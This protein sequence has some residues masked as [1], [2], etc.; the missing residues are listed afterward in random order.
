MLI[1]PKNQFFLACEVGVEGY[2]VREIQ[3]SMRAL[4]YKGN[5]L[6]SYQGVSHTENTRTPYWQRKVLKKGELKVTYNL[7]ARF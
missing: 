4:K 3:V 5:N 1:I 2:T 6:V 7:T